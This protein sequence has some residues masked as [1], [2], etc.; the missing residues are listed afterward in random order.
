MSDH[1]Y[2]NS[3]GQL[4]DFTDEWIYLIII[5]VCNHTVSDLFISFVYERYSRGV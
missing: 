3:K 2:I 1:V 4:I 5:G